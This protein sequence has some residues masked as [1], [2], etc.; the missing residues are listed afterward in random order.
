M[1]FYLTLFHS[2]SSKIF[3]PLSMPLT[4]WLS[5]CSRTYFVFNCW[6]VCIFRVNRAS[7]LWWALHKLQH[8]PPYSKFLYLHSLCLL[9]TL[10]AH[11]LPTSR[12]QSLFPSAI[13]Y[14]H[15]FFSLSLFLGLPLLLYSKG[16][17][18]MPF[19]SSLSDFPFVQVCAYLRSLFLCVSSYR[20]PFPR[21]TLSPPFVIF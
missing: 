8:S 12:S 14:L 15:S 10:I 1:Y 21:V 17:V 20:D 11:S 7:T 3:L 4:S 5:G 6:F 16:S 9:L 18:S 2:L 13:S 19:P